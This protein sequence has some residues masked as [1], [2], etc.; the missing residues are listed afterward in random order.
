LVQKRH[1][2][3][4]TPPDQ[5]GTETGRTDFG[6]FRITVIDPRSS[7]GVCRLVVA[8]DWVSRFAMIDLYR[9]SDPMTGISAELALIVP[10][11][12]RTGT[13]A[14]PNAGDPPPPRGMFGDAAGHNIP[15]VD[16]ARNE[17]GKWRMT[18]NRVLLANP[19]QN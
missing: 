10:Y 14:P 19:T 9:G 6:S 2:L 18:C 8:V 16:S 15:R 7:A 4:Q 13:R 1:G 3:A 12:M 5:S 17:Q 11:A